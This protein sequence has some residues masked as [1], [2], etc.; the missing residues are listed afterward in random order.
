MNMNSTNTLAT[1]NLKLYDHYKNFK[2]IGLTSFGHLGL[3]L[4]K[5]LIKI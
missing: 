5:S 2:H 1:S 4:R 3:F